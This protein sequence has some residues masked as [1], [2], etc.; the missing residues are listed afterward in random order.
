[1][2]TGNAS[3]PSSLVAPLSFHRFQRRG[4]PKDSFSACPVASCQCNGEARWAILML[5]NSVAGEVNPL[6]LLPASSS[7]SSST[8]TS[9]DPP[10]SQVSQAVRGGQEGAGGAEQRALLPS[11]RSALWYPD[12][13]GAGEAPPGPGSSAAARQFVTRP[14]W[15]RQAHGV[16]A[17]Q[18]TGPLARTPRP[19]H[20]LVDPTRSCRVDSLSTYC[21]VSVCLDAP[22]GENALL[23]AQ[24]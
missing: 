10:T 13:I 7:S 14:K 23:P 4:W 5:G 3:F 2:A 1:M 19:S 22:I 12:L 18:P 15:S 17:G 11:V 16:Q 24:R 9:T 8:C 21:V 6:W 20:P